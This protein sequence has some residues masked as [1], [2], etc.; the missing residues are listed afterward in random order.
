MKN[1][2]FATISLLFCMI[3]QAQVNNKRALVEE[4]P[5]LEKSTFECVY[6]HI[7]YD[8]DLDRDFIL[9][10]I[11]QLGRNYAQSMRYGTYKSDS[12]LQLMDKK[13]R[14]ALTSTQL[15]RIQ[16]ANRWQGSERILFDLKAQT[17][18]RIECVDI[19]CRYIEPIPDFDWEFL[20]GDKT[21]LGYKCRKARCSFRGREWTAWYSTDIKIPYGPFILRGLPG[22]ILMAS[23][24]SGAH[25]FEAIGIRTTPSDI[26]YTKKYE[27]AKE[28][29]R[30][31]CY[32]LLKEHRF[33]FAKPWWDS[34][35]ADP[36]NNPRPALKHL[37]YVPYELDCE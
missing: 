20:P 34:Y 1:V 33:E 21:V 30:K 17:L 24:S 6:T 4:M 8:A 16:V 3:S 12:V 13:K 2:L 10:E 26:Y 19:L 35:N 23:D 36:V 9:E 29:S 27:L 14:D 37:P 25:T 11:L 15:N 28:V 32:R 5:V 22:L 31:E 7:E 18:N